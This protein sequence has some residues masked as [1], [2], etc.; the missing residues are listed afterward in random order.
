MTL[1]Q[2]M[3]KMPDRQAA[4]ELV[5]EPCWTEAVAVGEEP[6]VERVEQSVTYRQQMERYE[7]VTAG[8]GRA[9][10]VQETADPYSVDFPAESGV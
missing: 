4:G 6:F 3:Q 5:R 10:A 9:W 1:L 8:G 2:F 7:V